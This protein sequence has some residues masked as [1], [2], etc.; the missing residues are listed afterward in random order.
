MNSRKLASIMITALAVWG[1]DGGTEPLPPGHTFPERDFVCPQGE[2]PLCS[3]TV[4]ANDDR[5]RT[6]EV[7]DELAGE[8]RTYVISAL[9]VPD[10]SDGNAAGFNLDGLNSGDV[11]EGDT[12]AEQELDYGSTTDPDQ[13]GVDN[14]LIEVLGAVGTVV[15]DFDVNESLRE[16]I[17]SGSLLLLLE[18]SGID[19]FRYDDAVSVQIRLGAVPAG[20]TLGV[21]GGVLDAGQA[22]DVAM[23]LGAAVNGDIYDGR[24]RVTA[25]MLNINITLEGMSLELRISSPQIRFDISETGLTNGQIGGTVT[26]DDLIEA[27]VEIEAV[28]EFCGTDPECGAVRELLGGFADITPSADDPETCEALSVGIAFDGTTATIN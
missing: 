14:S 12:C 23:E 27:A 10:G 25:Q 15:D 16:Q 1:C 6:H 4:P 24:V 18:V 21:T 26:L 11:Y 22:Y 17:T 8:T 9:T 20:A 13:V 7:G 5:A 19:S 2:S 28:Q 3:T